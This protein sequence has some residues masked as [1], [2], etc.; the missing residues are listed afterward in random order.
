MRTGG[1]ITLGRYNLL[2]E[3]SVLLLTSVILALAVWFTLAGMN[4][5]YLDM[6]LNDAA[7]VNLFMEKHLQEARAS[8][9]HLA[10]LTDTERSPAVLKGFPAFSDLYR[11]DPGLRVE[12]IYKSTADSQVFVGYSFTGGKLAYYLR[13]VGDG[14]G[15]PYSEIMRGYEDDAPSVYFALRHG[16]RYYAGRLELDYIQSFLGQFSSFSGTPVLLVANNGFVMLSGAPDLR[17]PSFDLVKW[18]GEPSTDRRLTAGQRS[19][20]PV[21][22]PTNAIGA[23]IVALIP[24]DVLVSQ[25]TGLLAF[26]LL[27]TG[28]LI[29]LAMAKNARLQ[30]LAVEPLADLAGKMRALELGGP[31]VETE[32][33]RYRFAELAAIHDRF[34]SMAKAIRQREQALQELSAQ[35]QA[36]SR[37][38]SQ[39]LAHMSHEIRTP[40]N[41]VLGLAQL[42]E[43][44]EMPSDQQEM[45]RQIG[46]S[47]ASLLGIINDILD[48][49]KIEAG[50]LGIVN[51][52]FDPGEVLSQVKRMIEPLAVRKHLEY[53]VETPMPASTALLGDASRLQQIL[54]NLAGNAVKFTETGEVCL[55]MQPLAGSESAIRLRFEVRDTGIG[56]DSESLGRLFQPFSQADE[57]INRRFGGTG[58]GLAISKRLVELMGGRIGASSQPGQGSTFWFEIPFERAAA[59]PQSSE[60][61]EVSESAGPRLQ[62][63]RVL[64]VDDN[65][66]NLMVVQ[67]ALTLEGA[68][69]SLAADGL[70]ALQ[71]LR[72]Q[73]GQFDVVL[74]DIQMPVMD[75]LTATREIRQ[76]PGLS[77]LPVIALTAGV[78]AE[79]RQAAL[80]AGVDDFLAKPLDL[81]QMNA[82]LAPLAG[83]LSTEPRAQSAP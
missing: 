29:L 46:E 65:R 35:S 79:E 71:R 7:R 54:I 31:P 59:F 57:S 39:F 8:L 14:R 24:T 23:R 76:D 47:G 48:F 58:L 56:I 18:V 70:Q 68:T 16:S 81:Q 2:L 37:A 53:R 66:I 10:E 17:I 82:L 63:L 13:T 4:R 1:G 38:K 44:A 9:I 26:F 25:R 11:L 27:F 42:L 49:S 41:A 80:E 64:A 6:R 21:I 34:V 20:I 3:L 5:K 60:R 36:A 62:G 78:L 67:R 51:Q 28:G 69:V 73:P 30:K 15:N 72:S 43:R 19:W 74:M 50:Q 12:R 77:G 61:T 45:V 22:S 52:P 32:V 75:G 55:T 33:I 40:M 83:K